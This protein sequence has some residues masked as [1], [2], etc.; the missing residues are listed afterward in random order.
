MNAKDAKRQIQQMIQFIRQEA[1]EKA[2]ELNVKT[3]S[4]FTAEKLALQTQATIQIREEFEQKRKARHT[5]KK[6]DRS[7]RVNEA[8]FRVMRE[9]DTKIKELKNE[10]LDRLAEV[11]RNPKYPELIRFCISQGL[12]NLMEA[13]VTLRC[14][15]EDLEIVQGQVKAAIDMYDDVLHK[16][17]GV[18]LPCTVVVDEENFLAPGPVE[19]S[20]AESCGGGVELSARGRQLIC[21]NTLDS[22]LDLAFGMLLPEVRGLLFGTRP[23]PANAWVPKSG[24]GHGH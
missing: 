2:E 24:H 9:R 19:G 1:R 20:D 5:Q 18:K 10:T 11:S 22:R 17:S 21:R 13:K 14:R 8:K 23:K 6:I 3:E 12:L 4:E 16:H 7:K 15:K